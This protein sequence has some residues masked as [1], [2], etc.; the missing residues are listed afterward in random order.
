MNDQDVNGAEMGGERRRFMERLKALLMDLPA[1]DREEAVRYYSDYLDD[2]GKENEAAALK[3]LGS[4]E[5][6]ADT[7]RRGLGETDRGGNRDD[8]GR[9]EYGSSAGPSGSHFGGAP[10]YKGQAPVQ[11]G[12]GRKRGAGWVVLVILAVLV[13]L[14]VLLPIAFAAAAVV[15]AVVFSVLAA[16]F[17]I[18]IAGIVVLCVGIGLSIVAF[19]KMAVVPAAAVYLLGGGLI[20]AGIGLA[21]TVFMIWVCFQVVPFLMRGL[22]RLCSLPFRRRKQE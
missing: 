22:V 4:P 11:Q 13:L 7:I 14:P 10:L 1:A 3:A 9:G 6:L 2:A 15:L 19:M 20:C 16:I 12:P 8:G 18:L 5:Q 17:C 21:M